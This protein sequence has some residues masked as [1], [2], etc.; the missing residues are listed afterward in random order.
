MTNQRGAPPRRGPGAGGNF[1]EGSLPGHLVRLTAF[2]LL[3]MSSF[4]VAAL[5]ETIY[6]GRI[7][8]APL[9]AVSFTFPLVMVMQGVAM[10]LGV[11]ASSV[12]ARTI[13]AGDRERVRRLVSH[14]LLLVLLL[15]STMAIL[16]YH[17]APQLFMLLGAGPE[18]LPLIISYVDVWLIGLPLFTV[19]MVGTN[20]I[21]AVGNPSVPGYVMTLGSVMQILIGPLF[22]FGLGPFPQMGLPGAALAFVIARTI[23]AS[24]CLYH[25][26]FRERLLIANLEGTLESWRAILHVGLP[27]I[28]TNLINPVSMGIITRLLASHG[29]EVVAGYGVGSRVD[30]LVTI[31]VMAL[32]SSIGPFVGQNWGAG[33]YDRVTRALS[34]TYR[35][36]LLWGLAAF[37]FMLLFGESLVAL[38]NDDPR[39]V[40]VA[41]RFLVII[42]LS[43]GFMGVMAISSSCFNAL[44]KPTPPLVLSI[45]RMLIVYI[46]TAILFDHLWGYIGIFV[47]TSGS[48]IVMGIIAWLWN[49]SVIT[50]EI[51]RMNGEAADGTQSPGR[52]AT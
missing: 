4:M 16:G 17:F 8:T 23:S 19:S 14:C 36:S 12:V 48:T 6:I 46:P 38:I 45:N 7:G 39:V 44:G 37:I 34:L 1:T 24:Y 9:A 50:R 2:M 41:A 49:R 28:A 20:L 21:R 40:E 27:A 51:S 13:G 18:I 3:G 15:I 26:S 43:I 5:V 52:L 22:I 11:G 42:P 31:I 29:P 33:K 25:L 47:A 35:F 10:G 32:S 30:S